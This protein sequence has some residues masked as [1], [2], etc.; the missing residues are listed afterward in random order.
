MRSFSSKSH[1]ATERGLVMYVCMYILDFSIPI[2]N[3][4]ENA[5][6]KL[7]QFTDCFMDRDRP[8]P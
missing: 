3:V 7:G 4:H 2:L 5:L 1:G 8:A 6:P